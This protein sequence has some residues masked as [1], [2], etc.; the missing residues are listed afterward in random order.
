MESCA[1]GELSSED[2]SSQLKWLQAARLIHS[3]DA[4]AMRL[5]RRTACH[6]SNG[7]GCFRFRTI[8]DSPPA[9]VDSRLELK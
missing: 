5:A 8:V 1:R 2:L 6:T 4:T 3:V 9:P 7:M